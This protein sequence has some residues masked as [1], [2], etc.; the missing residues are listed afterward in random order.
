[1]QTECQKLPWRQDAQRRR[2]YG[3]AYYQNNK[4]KWKLRG[5]AAEKRA[6]YL[7]AWRRDNI[8]WRRDYQR[9]N[10][11]RINAKARQRRKDNPLEFSAK[12]RD[13]RANNP[14]HRLG[15]NLRQRVREAFGK[16]ERSGRSLD[17]LGCTVM[18]LRAYLEAKF[19]PGMS[20]EN[21]G[22]KGWHIDHI[23]ACSMFDLSDPVQVSECFHFTNLQ[24][25]WAAENISKGGINRVR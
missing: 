24:P 12:E 7:I 23:R 2:E 22:P 5:E 14:Q 18:E 4:E 20:W 6:A 19:K 3:A 8:H 11:D 16:K 15:R 1:M 10:A 17:L 25:L 13:R 9:K 21:Y